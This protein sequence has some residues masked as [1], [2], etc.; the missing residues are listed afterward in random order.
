MLVV[1]HFLTGAAIASVS[2]NPLIFIP[3]SFASHFVLDTIPHSQ[4]AYKPWTT[5]KRVIILEMIDVLVAAGTLLVL[6]RTTNS[7][8]NLWL[9]ATAASLPDLDG[10]LY[11]KPFRK[12][13]KAPAIRLWSRFHESLQNETPALIGKI[14]QV[15]IIF[16]SLLVILG[17]K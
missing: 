15:F 16:S 6:I 17:K 13:L 1:T 7:A 14:T 3:V 9:G 4:P 2:S 10:F 11:L 5:T 8:T 12:F